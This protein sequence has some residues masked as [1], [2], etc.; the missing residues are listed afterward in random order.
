MLY[1]FQQQQ[2]IWAKKYFSVQEKL[3]QIHIFFP[4]SGFL[5]A[6]L[7]SGNFA[8]FLK[9]WAFSYTFFLLFALYYK[10]G[11]IAKKQVLKFSLDM[12]S[13]S[14]HTFF[15]QGGQFKELYIR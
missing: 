10:K 12:G 6:F 3:V 2:K 14:H 13:T 8:S 11:Y 5:M 4:K 9:L 15:V 7:L 1:L